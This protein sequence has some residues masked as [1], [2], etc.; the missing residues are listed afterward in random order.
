MLNKAQIIGRVGS[1]IQVRYSSAGEAIVNV[2]LATSEKWK[3]KET[4]EIKEKVEW[5]KIVAFGKTAE[6]MGEY[7]KKGD[8]IFV[9]GKMTTKKYEDKITGAE[10]FNFEIRVV[11]MKMLSPKQQIKNETNKNEK[12][13]TNE[14]DNDIPF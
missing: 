7:V 11:E 12:E 3:D 1:D 14:F 8:L 6:I 2:S 9:E 4:G 5:H 10:K 13:I